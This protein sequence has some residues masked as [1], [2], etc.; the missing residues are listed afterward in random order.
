M[1]ARTVLGDVAAEDLGLTYA[2]EHLIVDSPLVAERFP[3]IH[4]PSVEE[5]VA[6]VRA[7]AAAGVRTMVD[8]MPSGAGG[9]VRRLAQVSRATG[10]HVVAATGVHTARYYE[11]GAWALTDGPEALAARF[12]ADLEAGAGPAGGERDEAGPDSSH[13]ARHRAGVV[14][15]ATLGERPDGA[16][17]RAFEAAVQIQR[18]VG[19]PVLTHCEG[20]RGG[21]AQVE[22]LRDLGARLDRVALSHTDKVPD[23]AY[24]RELLSSGVSLVYDQALRQ[25]PD[26]RRGTAWLVAEMLSEG[27][28]DRVLLGTDGARRSLWGTLGGSPGLAWLAAEFTRVLA[29]WGVDEAAWRRLFVANPARFLAFVP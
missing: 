19:A 22:L 23:P 1:K 24:H 13:G 10:V 28:G 17:R 3:H 25:P 18:E 27:F 2:H 15:V 7:C 21:V 20:G 12:R 16:E 11:E 5:A 26:E 29:S 9:D 14:K 8:A 4:L 6:E